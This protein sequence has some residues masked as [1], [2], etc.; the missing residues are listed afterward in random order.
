VPR[1]RRA[2]C[3]ESRLT[4]CTV[5]A[6]SKPV[7]GRVRA[8][9][10][11][12]GV[13]GTAHACIHDVHARTHA[14]I[15]RTYAQNTTQHVPT[16][17]QPARKPKQKRCGV[18]AQDS[19]NAAVLSVCWQDET[20]RVPCLHTER[21]LGEGGCISSTF[22]SASSYVLHCTTTGHMSECDWHC[23]PWLVHDLICDVDGRIS[24][25]QVVTG[26]KRSKNSRVKD[27]EES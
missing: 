4:V 7:G 18:L 9:A 10:G 19:Q 25:I 3:F 20:C 12:C 24:A 8:W 17:Q 13:S 16:L 15:A 23:L 6:S 11:G 27:T 14:R 22:Y 1:G 5:K 2:L 26:R 21:W